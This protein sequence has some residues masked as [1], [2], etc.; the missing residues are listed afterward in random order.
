MS[1]AEAATAD[2]EANPTNESKLNLDVEI[3]EVGPCRKHVVVTIP[4]GDIRSIRGEAVTELADKAEVPGF[5]VGRI[6]WCR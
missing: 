4:E 1:D 2:P 6:G 5:R 3:S